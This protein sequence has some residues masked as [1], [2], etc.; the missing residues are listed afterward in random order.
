[1]INKPDLT[2]KIIQFKGD[3]AESY[4]ELSVAIKKEFGSATIAMRES[5]ATIKAATESYI[6]LGELLN[7]PSQEDLDRMILARDRLNTY[8]RQHPQKDLS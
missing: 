4:R 2:S 6:R 5:S 1:M 3:A 7:N 8:Q